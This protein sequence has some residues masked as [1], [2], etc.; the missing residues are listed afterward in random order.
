MKHPIGQIEFVGIA[1]RNIKDADHGIIA[2]LV[3]R[4]SL[5]DQYIIDI[6]EFRRNMFYHPEIVPWHTD[7]VVHS[8]GVAYECQGKGGRYRL[9]G[10]STGA[11]DDNRGESVKVYQDT[12]TGKLFHRNVPAFDKRMAATGDI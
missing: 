5:K 11:G 8:D 7:Y 4:D 2:N 10:E 1:R 6:S 12:V 3:V 9:I